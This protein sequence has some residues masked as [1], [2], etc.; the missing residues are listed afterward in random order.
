MCF[1]DLSNVEFQNRADRQEAGPSPGSSS[2]AYSH[3]NF[4][5]NGYNRLPTNASIEGR[6]IITKEHHES[7][8]SY[9]NTCVEHFS[10]KQPIGP[11]SRPDKSVEVETPKRTA[12]VGPRRRS[13]R[14]AREAKMQ[15]T[16]SMSIPVT[17]GSRINRRERYRA[18]T[19]EAPQTYLKKLSRKA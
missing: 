8:S 14:L 13:P 19:N 18:A 10:R 12:L 5:T 16:P 17:S 1:R 9:E 15:L 11:G 3:R 2:V 7:S 6:L 4:R